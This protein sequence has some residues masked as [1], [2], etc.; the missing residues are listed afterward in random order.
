MISINQ[1]LQ[2][3][4]KERF[5]PPEVFENI[6]DPDEIAYLLKLEA[7]NPKKIEYI[8]RVFGLDT[9]KAYELVKSRL[10]EKILK[11]PFKLT[12][13]NFFRTNV[14]YL[15]HA[16][17]GMSEQEKIYR[18]VV[19]PLDYYVADG[20]EYNPELNQ[21]C[22]M[23]QRWYNQAGFFLKGNEEKFHK[24]GEYNIPIGDYSSALNLEPE[25]YEFPKE[26]HQ[27]WF[28]HLTYSN[29]DRLSIEATAPWVPGSAVSFDRSHIHAPTNF[30]L[31]GLTSKVAVTMFFSYD[32]L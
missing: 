7:E 2:E 9:S 25:G 31:A 14:P 12:G 17:T 10:E 22:V 23:K 28:P 6:L 11:Y 26:L 32:D 18:I 1:S 8:G 29:F 15:V 16:D 20:Q 3:K 5:L 19:F 27:K 13:G 21:L 30:K 24:V 4:L